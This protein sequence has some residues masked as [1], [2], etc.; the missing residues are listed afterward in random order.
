MKEL[1]IKNSQF[2]PEHILQ[3]M[4]ERGYNGSNSVGYYEAMKWLCEKYKAWLLAIPRYLTPLDSSDERLMWEIQSRNISTYMAGDH[5]CSYYAIDQ[6][7]NPFEAD[8]EASDT[9]GVEV[10]EV[11]GKFYKSYE[12]AIKAGLIRTMLWLD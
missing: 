4:K 8:L 9:Y 7:D 11:N 3:M 5:Y 2:I 6:Y 10:Y 12:D 1:Q